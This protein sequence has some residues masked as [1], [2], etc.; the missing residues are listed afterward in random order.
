MTVTMTV[1]MPVSMTGPMT[2]PTLTAP[3]PVS[4]AAR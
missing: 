4:A 3:G 2:V 1:V